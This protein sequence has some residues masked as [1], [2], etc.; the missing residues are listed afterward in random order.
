MRTTL[1]LFTFLLSGFS[2]SAQWTEDHTAVQQTIQRLFDG[3]RSVDS[4]QIAGVFA[5]NAQ[6]ATAF[7]DK[8]GTPQYRQGSLERFLGSVAVPHEGLYDEKPGLWGHQ[9]VYP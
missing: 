5:A 7:Y 4:L 8:E 6:M 3:M 2:L 9:F 1:L